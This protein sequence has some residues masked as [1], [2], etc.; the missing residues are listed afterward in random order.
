MTV[1]D[2]GNMTATWTDPAGTEWPLTDTSPEVGYF[3]TMGPAGWHATTYE[4]VTDPMARGGESVRFVRAQPARF[5]WPIYVGGDTHLEWL[6]RHRQIKKAFISTLHTGIP[7]TL[8][9]TRPDGSGRKIACY[10]ESGFEGQAGEGRLYSKDAITLFAPDGYWNDLSILSVTRSY[11]PGVDFLNPYPRVSDSLALGRSTLNNPG[12]VAAWP[13][14]TIN[15]PMS[16]M[17]ATNQSTGQEFSLTYGLLAGEQVTINTL[18]PAVRG[19]AGQN[20]SGALDWPSA[21]L[22]PLLPGDNDV[23]FN[24]SGGLSGT[25]VTLAYSPRYEGA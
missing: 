1:V 4:I 25:S 7:G 18:Q 20:L 9:I 16:A 13:T 23:V 6:Q 12:D 19:P 24:V 3:T 21:Y 2:V 15:G 14:W 22:W 5:V 17:T 8:T 10:Y 11:L